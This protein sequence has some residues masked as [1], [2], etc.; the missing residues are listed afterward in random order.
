MCVCHRERATLHLV[1]DPKDPNRCIKYRRSERNNMKWV[2]RS[3]HNKLYGRTA[4][5]G[6]STASPADTSPPAD[7]E[8]EP[9]PADE[10][11][12]PPPAD[13]EPAPPPADEESAPPRNDQLPYMEM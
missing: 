11:S 6:E 13:E 3:E 4:R 7:E 1:T 2:L 12:E 10:E 5:A 8:S 9:P